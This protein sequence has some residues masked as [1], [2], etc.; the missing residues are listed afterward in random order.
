MEWKLWEEQE[1][2]FLGK[3]EAIAT[4]QR[5]GCFLGASQNDFLWF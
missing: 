1:A 3:V 2:I 5:Y 4:K